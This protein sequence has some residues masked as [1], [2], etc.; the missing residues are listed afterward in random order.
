MY[1]ILIHFLAFCG[2]IAVPVFALTIYGIVDDKKKSPAKEEP[3][4]SKSNE[5]QRYE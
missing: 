1:Q 4:Q 2:I 5:K 3:S